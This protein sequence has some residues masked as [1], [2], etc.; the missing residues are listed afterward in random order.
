M[1]NNAETTNLPSLIP[2]C[3]AG[4]QF[5][6][7]TLVRQF[8]TGVFRFALS[9]VDDPMEAAE[10]AQETFIAALRSLPSYQEKSSFKAWLFTIALNISRSRLR[11]RKMMERLRAALGGALLLESRKAK[12]PEEAV[13]QGERDAAVWRALSRLDEKHRLPVVLRY[14]QEL[15]IAEIAQILNVNEGTIHSRLHHAR[16][17]LQVELKAQFAEEES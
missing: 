14:F 17:R 12:S 8:E 1:T 4:D 6:I 15:S 3:I 13:V 5:A 2:L 16:E 10:I 7:E 11:K 9:V